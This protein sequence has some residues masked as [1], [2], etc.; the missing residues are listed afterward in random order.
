MLG[1]LVLDIDKGLHV[2]FEIR[3]HD[4]LHG[5]P[6]KPDD[7]RQHIGTEHG[8]AARFGFKNDLTQD[9]AREF[10]AGFCIQH[11][12][13][14]I[15][16]HQLPYVLQRNICTGLRIIEPTIGIFFNC[17]DHVRFSCFSHYLFNL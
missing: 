15:V 17:A 1:Q 10:F 8:N 11:L 14:D 5:V 16:Q 12:K 9:A 2:L 13:A 6:V 7:M 4:A 3:S